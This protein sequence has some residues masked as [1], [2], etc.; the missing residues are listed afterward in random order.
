MVPARTW[1]LHAVVMAPTDRFKLRRQMAAAAG[2]KITTMLSLFMR[3]LYVIAAGQ[4][5]PLE[6]V[7]S[8][9]R[10]RG[11]EGGHLARASSGSAAKE[12]SGAGPGA[13]EI[14]GRLD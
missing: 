7:G 13:E 12:D 1:G 3:A 8:E 9:A 6:E 4:D 2:K 10:E 5:S 11:I 14:E